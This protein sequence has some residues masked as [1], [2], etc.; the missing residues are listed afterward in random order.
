[1][2]WGLFERDEM[3]SGAGTPTADT[4]LCVFAMATSENLQRR[5]YAG[6]LLS[7]VLKRGALLGSK[8]ALLTSSDAAELL[9]LGAGFSILE[10]WRVSSRPRWVIA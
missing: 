10:F 4:S 1:M 2:A 7:S 3:V 5:G 8:Q 6:R 9:Y